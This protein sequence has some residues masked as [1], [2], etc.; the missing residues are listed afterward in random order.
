[1]IKLKEYLGKENRDQ[2]KYLGIDQSSIPIKYFKNINH[3][4]PTTV[5]VESFEL[6][7]VHFFLYDENKII[8]V[9]PNSNHYVTKKDLKLIDKWII[10]NE[11]I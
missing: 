7:T 2:N 6:D 4:K 5:F 8:L 11:P 9:S 1:M 3:M 10:I